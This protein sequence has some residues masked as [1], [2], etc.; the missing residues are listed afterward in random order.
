MLFV[1]HE[2]AK[3]SESRWAEYLTHL[4]GFTTALTFTASEL[5]LLSG[6]PLLSEAVSTKET[7]RAYYDSSAASKVCTWEDFLWARILFDTRALACEIT[8]PAAATERKLTC[9]VPFLD[10]IN[11]SP[12]AQLSKQKYNPDTGCLELHAFAAVRAG[13]EVFLN[14]GPLPNSQLLLY[15]GFV[16][17][18]NPYET[19]EVDLAL[20]E[21]PDALLAR[22]R[23]R[24]LERSGIPARHHLSKLHPAPLLRAFLRVACETDPARLGPDADPLAGPLSEQSEESAVETLESIAASLEAVQGDDEAGA[25]DIDTENAALARAYVASVVKPFLR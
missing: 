2:K 14:Y 22:C 21:E 17:P 18:N 9:L 3:G 15:Y 13:C 11:H 23:Q 25:D 16:D 8:D 10:M 5:A 12:R 24:V 1:L 6:T 4:P 7:L 20:P 19:A